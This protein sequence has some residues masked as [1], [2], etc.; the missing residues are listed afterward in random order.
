MSN[1]PQ[2]RK[3]MLSEMRLHHKNENAFKSSYF[4]SQT[5]HLSLSDAI[6]NFK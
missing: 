6:Q 1:F 5:A 4:F 2:M 3:H